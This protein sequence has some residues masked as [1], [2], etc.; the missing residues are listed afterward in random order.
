[1][2]VAGFSKAYSSLLAFI[3]CP[4]E[5][6]E[7]LKVAAPPY[8]Y[9]GPSPVASLAT[10]LAGFEVN[11]ARGDLLRF[12][13]VAQDRGR[14]RA[15]DELDIIRQTFPDTRSSRCRSRDHEEIDDVG[16]FLFDRGDLRHPGRLPAGAEGRGRVPRPGDRRQHGRGDRASDDVLGEL[17]AAGSGCGRAMPSRPEAA[18]RRERAGALRA[19]PRRR[20]A[21]CGYLARVVA[22]ALALR[23]GR[24]CRQRP[25][26]QRPRRLVRRSAI[27]SASR[28]TSRAQELPWVLFALGQSC[29]SWATS[30]RTTT[31]FFGTT[32]RTRRSATRCIWRF[33]RA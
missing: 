10:V 21:G 24:R 25:A 29:S 1:M 6:K 26:D 27:L 4:T 23:F 20:A 17:A 15:L 11:D 30:S 18:R 9:S 16:R 22:V 12:A 14:P 3:A 19:G 31:E 2:L 5:L 32:C 7:L 13:T 28:S 33:T 8:L